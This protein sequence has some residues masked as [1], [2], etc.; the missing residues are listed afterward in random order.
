MGTGSWSVAAAHGYDDGEQLPFDALVWIVE[1]ICASTTLPVTVDFERGYAETSADVRAN[2]LRLIDAG[3]IGFN[4]EDGDPSGDGLRAVSEQSARIEAIRAAADASEVP[5]FINARTDLFMQPR[6][7]S[8]HPGRMDEALERAAAYAGAGA[9]GFFVPLLSRETLIEKL[10]AACAL[11]VNIMQTPDAPDRE[12]LAALGVARLSYGP[13]PFR[14][15]LDR[16]EAAARRAI[17]G[18]SPETDRASE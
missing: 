9:D 1:R 12:R 8:E 14:E 11:P 15:M 16:L 7:P 17:A 2:A 18:V 5:V 3:A 6:S 13:A 10:C 4:L